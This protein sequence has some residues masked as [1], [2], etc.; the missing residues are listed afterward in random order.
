[1]AIKCKNS[2]RACEIDSKALSRL[3]HNNLVCLLGCCEDSIKPK[4]VYEY[5]KNG[6]LQDHLHKLQSSP[7]M[8]SWATRIEV[9]LDAAKG[10]E[11]LHKLLLTTTQTLVV[12]HSFLPSAKPESSGRI[13]NGTNTIPDF[14]KELP[15]LSLFPADKSGIDAN[16][17]S[18]E[19]PP[20]FNHPIQ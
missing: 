9:A 15:I 16:S 6:N 20:R 10:I 3:S 1:M 14:T 8:S 2:V 17:D 13:W 19:T 12:E 11:Y 7:L 4:W 5:M 18:K